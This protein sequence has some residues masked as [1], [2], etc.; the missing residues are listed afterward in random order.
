[1]YFCLQ[2]NKSA[3]V[4][5]ES[6]ITLR[7]FWDKGMVT[8]VGEVRPIKQQGAQHHGHWRREMV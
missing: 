7:Q 2:F 4:S 3:L 5:D 8:L 6:D 1:M